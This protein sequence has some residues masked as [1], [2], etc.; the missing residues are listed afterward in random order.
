MGYGFECD[1][2]ENPGNTPALMGQFSERVWMTTPL[3]DYL[4]SAGYELGDTVTLCSDC[5]EAILT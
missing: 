4:K 3:G 1:R 2:C 5:T